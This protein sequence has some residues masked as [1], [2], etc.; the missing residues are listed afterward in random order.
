MKRYSIYLDGVWIVAPDANHVALGVHVPG[1]RQIAARH[2]E[3]HPLAVFDNECAMTTRCE[4][5]KNP[6]VPL[7]SGVSAGVHRRA[8]RV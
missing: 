2:V 8:L 4:V 6:R 1:L 7:R 5:V 3:V